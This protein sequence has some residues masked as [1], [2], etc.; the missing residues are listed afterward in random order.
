MIAITI[1]MKLHPSLCGSPR[2]HDVGRKQPKLHGAIQAPCQLPK[3]WINLLEKKGFAAD[4]HCGAC[5]V[6]SQID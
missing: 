3:N 5:R 6:G 1:F 4:P 2:F